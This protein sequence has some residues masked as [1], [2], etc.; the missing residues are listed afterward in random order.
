VSDARPRVL[1]ATASKHGATGELGAE[2]GRVL[3]EAGL[4]VTLADAADVESLRGWDGVVLGSA[5]YVGRWLEDARKLVAD[6]AGE[7]DGTPVWLFSSGP[8]GDPPKP[9]E[10]PADAAELVRE[11]KAVEHRVFPGRIDKSKLG[12]A[13]RAVVRVVG[14]AEGDYRDIPAATEWAAGIARVLTAKR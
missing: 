10:E 11:T 7:L 1:V 8:I 13:E 9:V 3:E 5:V 12:F 2:I 6:H 4:E 14:A